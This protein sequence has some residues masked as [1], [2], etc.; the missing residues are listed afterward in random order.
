MEGDSGRLG[1]RGVGGSRTAETNSP[2]LRV[3]LSAGLILLAL[4][5]SV[6]A[7]D[8]LEK[9]SPGHL[10]PVP[11][12]GYELPLSPPVV[13]FPLPP[14]WVTIRSQED[15][16]SFGAKVNKKLSA[17]C[18]MGRFT[19]HLPLRYR[20][21][22]KNDV[23]GVAFGHGLNLDDSDKLARRDMIY[24]FRD[25]DSTSCMVAEIDNRDPRVRAA[26]GG[27]AA[28]AGQNGPGSGAPASK[29]P[30]PTVPYP[31]R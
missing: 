18:A 14:Q 26:A 7:A 31:T 22:F 11:P 3:A 16:R 12:G 19:E 13:R 24:L 21:V 2:R 10:P 4:A 5:P 15:W 9:T 28:A 17:A 27:G 25:G 20:A 30:M 6:F 8:R 29:R 23:F 1:G